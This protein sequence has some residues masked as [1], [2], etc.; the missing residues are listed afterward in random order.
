MSPYCEWFVAKFSDFGITPDA[1]ESTAALL[2]LVH[3]D[4]SKVGN[5]LE[6]VLTDFVCLIGPFYSSLSCME[7]VGLHRAA[8]A[9]RRGG[10]VREQ[11]LHFISMSVRFAV[12]TFDGKNVDWFLDEAMIPWEPSVGLSHQAETYLRAGT[13]QFLS[14]FGVVGREVKV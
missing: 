12:R 9:A 1:S 2:A 3:V 6:V 4:S 8:E 14:Q 13:R 10:R 5:G 11:G 7:A